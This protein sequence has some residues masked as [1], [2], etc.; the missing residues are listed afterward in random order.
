MSHMLNL[1][2]WVYN[3]IEHAVCGM[4]PFSNLTKNGRMPLLRYA[5]K[6]GKDM[7]VAARYVQL[8]SMLCPQEVVTVHVSY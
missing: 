3:T 4:V 1:L 7:C 6:S 2:E 5:G 8:T